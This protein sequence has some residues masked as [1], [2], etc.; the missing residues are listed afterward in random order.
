MFLKNVKRHC[1]IFSGSLNKNKNG[2]LLHLKLGRRNS[3]IY[4]GDYKTKRQENESELP[5]LLPRT[6]MG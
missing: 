2:E 1:V 5:H 3:A 6:Q 4:M